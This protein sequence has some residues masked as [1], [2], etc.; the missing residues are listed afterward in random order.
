MKTSIPLLLSCIFL[1]SAG[2]RKENPATPLPAAGKELST[3]PGVSIRRSAVPDRHR[4]GITADPRMATVRAENRTLIVVLGWGLPVQIRVYGAAAL[5]QGRYDVTI[6]G[7]GEG[8]KVWPL[9]KE[10]YEKAFSV[11]IHKGKKSLEVYVLERAKA[12]SL[13][14]TPVAA[15]G[16]STWGTARTSGGLRYRFKAASMED[17][18]WVL[19]GY[20]DTP[21]IDETGL[22]GRF[23]FESTMDRWKPETVFPA[24]EKLGLK[25]RKQKREMEVL[26]IEKIHAE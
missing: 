23:D 14:M 25:L 1:V 13:G 19:E 20:T 6:D 24:V 8:E 10:A 2:C 26:Q 17:L 12:G 16:Q 21:V 22:A 9:L 3:V 7:N 4:G 15:D 11:R 18:C 5:P